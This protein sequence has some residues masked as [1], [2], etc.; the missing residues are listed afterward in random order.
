[1]LP[2]FLVAV[3]WLGLL[4]LSSCGGSASETP[5][6]LEPDLRGQRQTGAAHTQ[7]RSEVPATD[8]GTDSG[9][10]GAVSPP[11]TWGSG[12]NAEQPSAGE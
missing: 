12:S 10:E 4:G 2:R 11:A 9:E 8:E 6:P 1:M 5:P 3:C 7:E